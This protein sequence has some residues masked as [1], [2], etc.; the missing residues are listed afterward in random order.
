[1]Q[2][3]MGVFGSFKMGYFVFII[4]YENNN[5]RYDVKTIVFFICGLC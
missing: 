5:F 1:M 4:Y 3:G 2:F